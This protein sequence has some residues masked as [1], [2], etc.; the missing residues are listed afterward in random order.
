MRLPF[1][2]LVIQN[3][4]VL[5]PVPGDSLVGI[6]EISPV[7]WIFLVH[8]L[9]NQGWKA[10][11]LKASRKEEFLEKSKGV[12]GASEEPTF[13]RAGRY[14][15]TEDVLRDFL[16][17]IL[18]QRGMDLK[19]RL[20]GGWRSIAKGWRTDWISIA[21]GWLHP[22]VA[23]EWCNTKGMEYFPSGFL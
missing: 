3:C 1:C 2:V 7:L 5:D 22:T 16:L 4:C 9:R 17:Y 11:Y 10:Y 14:T 21:K 15:L 13:F 20:F 19:V 8:G 12:K 23:S 6:F 18:N